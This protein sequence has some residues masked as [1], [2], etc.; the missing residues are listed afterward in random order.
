MDR[1]RADLLAMALNVDSKL[2]KM[3]HIR[4]SERMGERVMPGGRNWDPLILDAK[5]TLNCDN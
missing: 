4:F 2:G 5:V 1:K 3:F